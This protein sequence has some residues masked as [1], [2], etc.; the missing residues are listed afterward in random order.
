MSV[1]AHGID[2]AD[3]RHD[4][5]RV[6]N[7]IVERFLI[8]DYF[9]NFSLEEVFHNRTLAIFSGLLLRLLLIAVHIVLR[10][11]IKN[12][13]KAISRVTDFQNTGQIAASI[14]VVWSTPNRA[15]SIVIKNLVALLTEL[16]CPQDM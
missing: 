12:I 3:T 13:E 4:E 14:A 6:M 16:M 7:G 11:C 8:L 15:K 5:L 9:L 1:Y 10:C 2:V